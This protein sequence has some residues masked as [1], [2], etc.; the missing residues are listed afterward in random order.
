MAA[1][2]QTNGIKQYFYIWGTDGKYLS[3]ITIK[4]TY[5]L[6]HLIDL[7]LTITGVSLG[8]SEMNI[9]IRNLLTTPLQLLIVKLAIPVLIAWVVPGRFLIPAIVFL[10]LVICW[11]IK[12]LLLLLF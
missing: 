8:F 9:L 1:T 11:N 12:E 10:F 5:V 4:A 6:L 3:S 7:I 2:L